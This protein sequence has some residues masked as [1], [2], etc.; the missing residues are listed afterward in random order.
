[1]PLSSD[2]KRP[3]WASPSNMSINMGTMFFVKSEEGTNPVMHIR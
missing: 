3:L 2:V 1:M